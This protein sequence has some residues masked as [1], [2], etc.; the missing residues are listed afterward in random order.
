MPHPTLASTTEQEVDRATARWYAICG[1]SVL[2]EVVLPIPPFSPTEEITPAW[3]I[4]FGDSA[5]RLFKPSGDWLQLLT[6]GRPDDV[7]AEAGTGNAYYFRHG[8]DD[9][10][11]WSDALATVHISPDGR[12]V[13]VYPEPQTDDRLLGLLLAGPM[14]AVVL[15]QLGQPLL[16][17]SAVVLPF[18]AVAF[19]GP[20]GQGKSTMAAGFLRHGASLLTDDMLRLQVEGDR[21]QSVPGPAIMKLWSSTV[22]HT[23][24]LEASALPN[25]NGASEKK[26]LWI[27]A[28][29]DMV[30]RPVPLRA[31][32]V[33]ERYKPTD[34]QDQVISRDLYGPQA[35]AAIVAQ[36]YRPILST[37]V[38]AKFLPTFARLIKQAPVR[39][40]RYPSGFEH[41]EMVYRHVLRDLEE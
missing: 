34:D 41:Q 7:S 30:Q 5:D 25:I 14:T 26:L 12:N 3:T 38:V 40:L 4:R 35:F 32:Y 10:W 13:D 28:R 18:G 24:G 37:S 6:C 39:V 17:A 23:L 9:T 33:L 22:V 2:S 31:L 11:F 19:L 1:L 16:H 20:R 36:V 15:S 8:A 29:F 21:V 27:D